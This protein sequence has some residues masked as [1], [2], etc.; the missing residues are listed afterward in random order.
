MHVTHGMEK[1]SHLLL[2]RA[3]HSRIGM[4]CRRNAK[5]RGEIKVTSS[6]NI[7]NVHA[8]RAVPYD[9]PRPV[10]LDERDVARL[11]PPEPFENV[12]RGGFHNSMWKCRCDLHTPRSSGGQINLCICNWKRTGSLS[13]MIISTS[14]RREIAF[15]PAG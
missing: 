1:P 8:F 6:F 5:G 14:S 4:S 3:H 7:P 2:S 10:R 12:W 9:G 11:V 13:A 15:C